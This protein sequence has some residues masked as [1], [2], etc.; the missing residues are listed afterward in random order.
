MTSDFGRFAI[1][2]AHPDD[3]VLWMGS[4]L[5]KAQRIVLCFGPSVRSNIG[6]ARSTA[7]ANLPFIS[8]VY[9]ELLEAD[10]FNCAN[11]K[12][13]RPNSSGLRLSWW[14]GYSRRRRYNANFR[15]LVESLS[16]Q[17]T[18]VDTIITHNPWGEYGHEE[19]VQVFNAV[20]EV[21]RQ[22]AKSVWVSCYAGRKSMVYATRCLAMLGQASDP[23]PIDQEMCERIKK[24]Y[25]EANCWTWSSS[26]SWAEHEYFY[27]VLLHAEP[28]AAHEARPLLV[29]DGG[30]EMRNIVSRAVRRLRRQLP[31]K[32]S[33]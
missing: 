5:T 33:S 23:L 1:V 2:V 26:H 10:I 28:P 27:P 30:T 6:K 22:S 25:L 12:S 20:T 9:L 11:W 29:L 15:K 31:W 16:E 24:V 14:A 13:P 7:I 17:L 19:H 4:L 3:E 8:L 32:A 18:K 21:A